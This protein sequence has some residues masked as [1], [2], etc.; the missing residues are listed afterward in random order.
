MDDNFK[1]YG[2]GVSGFS[3]VSGV[4]EYYDSYLKGQD[5]GN[6]LEINAKGQV[7][8]FLGE[9]QAQK[10][11]DVYLTIDAHLQ[12]AA[13]E[14]MGEKKGAFILM[15]SNTGEVL[16]LVSTPSF[17]P[18]MFIRGKNTRQLL[19]DETHPLLNRAIA[20]ELSAGVYF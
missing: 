3:G 19:F 8:G 11:Q 1:K 2:Y 14:S 6:S 5:G 9:E 7:V 17:D 12:Q 16:V 20:S 13:Y 18:N 4:E 10:G 15:D